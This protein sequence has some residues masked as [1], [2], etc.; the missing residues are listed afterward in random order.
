M[1]RPSMPSRPAAASRPSTPSINRPSTPSINR[2]S[3][4]LTPGSRPGSVDFARPATRPSTPGLTRRQPSLNWIRPRDFAIACQPAFDRRWP[5][6]TTW[7]WRWHCE[8]PCV[9]T[10]PSL[11]GG[12]T[13]VLPGLGNRQISTERGL[14]NC[15][16]EAICKIAVATLRIA[17][18]SVTTCRIVAKMCAKI[19]K[20]GT[21]TFMIAMTIGI[22]A[23]GMAM[24]ATGGTTCGRAHRTDGLRHDDVGAQPRSLCFGY[25]GYSNPYYTEP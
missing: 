18:A 6:H 16:I 7:G 14:V 23:V 5:R 13:A 4:G 19:G 22:M 24:P 2:P 21:T 17:W 1:S 11:P 25:W 3:T 9:G 15:P 10:R 12:S 20:T 8:S